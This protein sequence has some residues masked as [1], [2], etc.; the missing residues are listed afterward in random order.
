[1]TIFIY[2]EFTTRNL[3]F[4]S[5]AEQKTLGG[6]CVFVCGT[7]GMGG[8]AIMTLIRAGVGKLI[9]ADLDTFEVSNLNRQLFA[10]LD[11]I[12][13]DKAQATRDQCLRI[14]PEAQIEVLGAD[15]TKDVDRLVSSSDVVINGTDD[16][17]ASL[18]LYRTAKKHNRSVIDAY[19]SPLPSVYVTA[20]KSPMPEE[21]LG[22]PTIGTE[23]DAITAQMRSD[24][25]MAE[26][27]HVMLHSS[28]R[29]HIDLDLAGEM[30]AG[31]RN[32]MSFAPMVMMAGTLMAGEAL[33]II[34]KRPSGT[35][36]RGW[37][38]NTHSG[39]IE[40]PKNPL[41]TMVMKPLVR[42]ALIKMMNP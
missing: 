36:H 27:T 19:A 7:G 42:R 25:V 26:A 17:S 5:E 41:I 4:V 9:L 31:T 2:E 28:S 20:P 3:G 35:D 21:W 29:H 38:L 10:T 33:N 1:M 37:F 32:R 18:L 6:A 14:N 16:L 11:T 15:W 13:Q 24:A 8:S 12:D 23:W 39:K 40:R 22:F 34:L 30:V